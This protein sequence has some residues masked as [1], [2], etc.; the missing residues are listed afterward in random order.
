MGWSLLKKDQ[1]EDLPLQGLASGP[2]PAA[3]GADWQQQT[4]DLGPEPQAPNSN[5]LGAQLAA[6]GDSTVAI[7][8]SQLFGDTTA[9]LSEREMFG[10]DSTMIVAGP[11][12]YPSPAQPQPQPQG[13]AQGTIPLSSRA[14]RVAPTSDASR[15]E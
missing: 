10:D 1:D 12:S 4:V 3:P 5:N 14:M 6:T 8:A 11:S 9:E 15:V 13:F 2:G 7:P